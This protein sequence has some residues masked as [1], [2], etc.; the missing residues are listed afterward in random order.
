M[1]INLKNNIYFNLHPKFRLNYH[2]L[3][4]ESQSIKLAIM[5]MKEIWYYNTNGNFVKTVLLNKMGEKKLGPMTNTIVLKKDVGHRKVKQQE[6][7]SCH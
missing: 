1:Y 2:E 3:W 6:P 5:N 7:R 4:H